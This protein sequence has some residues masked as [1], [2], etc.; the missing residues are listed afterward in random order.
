VSILLYVQ[1]EGFEGVRLRTP[2][3]ADAVSNKCWAA[4]EKYKGKSEAPQYFS[5]TATGNGSEWGAGGTPEPTPLE[6]QQGANPSF[7]VD[8]ITI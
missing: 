1:I 4:V 8:R 2:P 7:S 3:V 5:G 6:P